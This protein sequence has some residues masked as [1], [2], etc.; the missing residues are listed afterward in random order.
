MED[1]HGRLIAKGARAKLSGGYA[2]SAVPTY[3]V[4]ELVEVVGF[5]TKKVKVKLLSKDYANR[6]LLRVLPRTLVLEDRP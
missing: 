3:L 5:T 2:D 1:L 4:H 6:D